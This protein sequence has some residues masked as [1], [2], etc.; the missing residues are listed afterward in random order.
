MCGAVLRQH[1]RRMWTTPARSHLHPLQW[2]CRKNP[3]S[4]MYGR[5]WYGMIGWVAVASLVSELP[6][7]FASIVG[8]RLKHSCGRHFDS[9]RLTSPG[10]VAVARW[11][12]TQKIGKSPWLVQVPGQHQLK[13]LVLWN[14]FWRRSKKGG[15]MGDHLSWQAQHFGDLHRKIS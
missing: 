8:K 14:I 3:W 2:K 9:I 7:V 4:E 10:P 13:G 12:W 5:V 6:H 11:S 15:I 1:H